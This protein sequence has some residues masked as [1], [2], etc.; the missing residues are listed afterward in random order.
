MT[1]GQLAAR[2]E[3]NPRTIRYYEHIGLLPAPERTEAGYRVY[4]AADEE[5]L[6]FIRSA[7]RLG[8]SLGEIKETIA[9]RERGERPCRYV[10]EVLERRVDEVSRRLSELREV[11]RELT[12]VL[13]R[14]H[15]EGVV[16]D[17][18]EYCHY[19]ERAPELVGGRAP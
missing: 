4:G 9:F 18:T 19:I 5:R 15:A 13:E 10:A 6:R 1:I 17:G 16:E 11:K 7:Q 8:L 2:L 14:M 12:V 3:L